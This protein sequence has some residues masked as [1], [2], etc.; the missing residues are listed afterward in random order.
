VEFF[1]FGISYDN[2]CSPLS[3]S[4]L[5]APSS[6]TSF[7]QLKTMLPE[8]T[9]ACIPIWEPLVPDCTS[10]PNTTAP[11]PSMVAMVTPCSSQKP[12]NQLIQVL[13]F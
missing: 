10:F 9:R 12:K 5:P 13:H 7:A 11:D 4:P 3:F 1:Y 6:R 2:P 8:I